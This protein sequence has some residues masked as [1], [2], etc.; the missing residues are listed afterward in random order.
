[1]HGPFASQ[2]TPSFHTLT[3]STLVPGTDMTEAS[4]ADKDVPPVFCLK[5]HGNK[6]LLTPFRRDDLLEG[7]PS[8][9]AADLTL[10]QLR[11]S[12]LDAANIDW[13]RSSLVGGGRDGYVWKVWFGE[14]GPYALK[15]VSRVTHAHPEAP[16]AP[17]L[18]CPDLS[19]VLGRRTERLRQLFCPS[20]RMPE[21]RHFTNYR[22]ADGTSYIPNVSL[23]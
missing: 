14:D 21:R 5:K 3:Q 6:K 20:E 19:S 13:E 4:D 7:Y 18:T 23:R 15:V 16:W 11:R 1:M 9:S 12:R 17:Y 22:D 2:S 8:C 10:P